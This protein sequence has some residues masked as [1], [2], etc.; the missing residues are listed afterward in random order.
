MDELLVRLTSDT[1]AVLG[2]R[3]ERDDGRTRVTTDDGYRH[4]LGV[5][6][7]DAGQETLG[8]DDIEGGDTEDVGGV[9]YT[10]LLED[11]GDDGNGGVDGVRDDKD[12]GLGGD[13]GDGSSEVANDGGVGVE[14]VITGHLREGVRAERGRE[15]ENL[16]LHRAVCG[17]LSAVSEMSSGWDPGGLPYLAG[18]TGGNDDD[19]SALEG[20]VELVCRVAM[21][22][23]RYEVRLHVALG[24][25]K[26]SGPRS[27]SRRG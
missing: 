14:E 5:S 21:D 8:A 11:S 13:T 23:S 12:V 3:E 9:I 7:S 2:L 6:T 22:L 17:R 19:V 10:G 26:G 25:G 4:L 16:G 1:L 15:G 20:L 24:E 27:W 18:N